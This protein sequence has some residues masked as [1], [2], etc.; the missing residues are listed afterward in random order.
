M[1]HECTA[2]RR[3]ELQW[4]QWAVAQLVVA[5]NVSRFELE[6]MGDDRLRE[7]LNQRLQYTAPSG[8]DD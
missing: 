8:S 1:A 3:I 7:L 4:R 6:A 2:L 5:L